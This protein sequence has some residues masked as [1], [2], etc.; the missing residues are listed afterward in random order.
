MTTSHWDTGTYEL[1]ISKDPEGD[2]GDLMLGFWSLPHPMD[3]EDTAS[4]E[5]API[6]AYIDVPAG[7][8]QYDRKLDDYHYG[9]RSFGE[10]GLLQP[11]DVE[12]VFGAR[13]G[14]RSNPVA[15][16]HH[17]PQQERTCRQQRKQLRKQQRLRPE[18]GVR[19]RCRLCRIGFHL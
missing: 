14:C 7:E 10:N 16:Q 19:P 18:A 11:E 5:D 17:P 9:L 1:L 6:L 12:P 2:E 8:H 13:L 3:A 4:D 15:G